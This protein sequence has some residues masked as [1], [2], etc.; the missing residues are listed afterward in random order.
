MVT[1]EL[2]NPPPELSI[3]TFAQLFERCRP[4]SAGERW[5]QIPWIGELWNGRKRA[6]EDSKPL[7]IWAMNGHPLGCV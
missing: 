2:L 7:F 5:T 4:K 1:T 6:A 3:D